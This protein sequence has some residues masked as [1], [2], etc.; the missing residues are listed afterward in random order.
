MNSVE[1][2]KVK[3]CWKKIKNTQGTDVFV[4]KFYQS[5]FEN[6]PEVRSLFPDNLKKQK[7]ILLSTLDNVINGINYIESLEKDLK[8]LGE[9]HK[10]IGIKKEQFSAFILTIVEAANF[11]TDN[12]LSSE[13]ISAWEKAF[14]EISNIMLQAY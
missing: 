11:T 1:N 13:E 9:H 2:Q 10:K 8:T 4:D 5:L 12:T 14:H 7:A 6:Y 3:D